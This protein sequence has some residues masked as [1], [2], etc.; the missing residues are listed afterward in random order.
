MFE[1]RP[2]IFASNPL[3]FLL[4]FRRVFANQWIEP[5]QLLRLQNRKLKAMVATAYNNVGYY[6]RL[7]DQCGISPQSI[8][9]IDDLRKI[10][11]TTKADLQACSTEDLLHRGFWGKKLASLYSSGS[12]GRPFTVYYDRGYHFIRNMLFLRGLM[13]AGYRIGQ[14]IL[15]VTDVHRKKKP[16]PGWRYGSILDHPEKLLA[17]LNRQKPDILYGCKTPLV[18]LADHI[19]ERGAKAHVPECVISTAEMLD[20]H[21]RFLLQSTF[22]EKV[23]DFYGSTEMGLVGWQCGFSSG[24][25]LSA[26]SVLTEFLPISGSED[27]A[28]MVMTNL[29]LKAMPLIRYDSGDIGVAGDGSPC[30]CGRMLPAIKRVEGR[31][32]DAIKLKDGRTVS[33]YRVTCAME[34]IP[35]VL[36]YQVIQTSPADLTVRLAVDGPG[37]GATGRAVSHA[38]R[39]VLGDGMQIHLDFDLPLRAPEGRKF[40][41]VES[42]VD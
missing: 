33:P 37:T 13:A 19:Q 31:R 41:V 12:T 39:S 7:F 25:H 18:R 15:L 21:S 32:I 2:G 22:S 40:R 10:P 26:D 8:E 29:D 30:G 3:D 24:Y 9:T 11:V 17:D 42:M 23:F 6:R 4:G 35:G 5:K 28:K 34:K 1:H 36:K 27:G 20:E 14:K 16:L 38:M